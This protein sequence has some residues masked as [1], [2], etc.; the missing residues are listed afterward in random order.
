MLPNRPHIAWHALVVRI[1]LDLSHP[2]RGTMWHRTTAIAALMLLAT[3][4]GGNKAK[5]ENGAY[6]IELENRARQIET[7]G[8]NQA[9][10][11]AAVSTNAAG[12]APEAPLSNMSD[13]IKSGNVSGGNMSSGH[14]PYQSSNSMS[15]D[16]G[17]HNS[18]ANGD[19]EPFCNI[20]QD[21]IPAA[22]CDY[23]QEVWNRL[24]S[25]Q[26]AFDVPQVMRRGVTAQVSFAL[27]RAEQGS[28]AS[29]AAASLLDS[30]PER[31]ATIRVGRRMAVNLSGEGFRIEPQGLQER[32]LGPGGQARWDWRV[33]PE[34][35]GHKTLTISA[36]V[37]VQPPNGPRTENLIRTLSQEVDVDVSA[38]D[39]A[40]DIAEASKSWLGIANEW[41][42]ALA[43]L[44]GGGVLALILALRRVR[45]KKEAGNSTPEGPAH[46][47]EGDD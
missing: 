38:S 29:A 11:N 12:P 36:Y 24:G 41:L 9:D 7:T 40:K 14:T 6:E 18:M 13:Y 2:G 21:R 32:D 4:G 10:A 31:S 19:A 15:G 28:D 25:G 27:V 16:V 47:P 44:I 22:E 35:R 46:P 23:Y 26:A 43:A 3:C 37:V 30:A 8:E 42:L 45:R 20:I 5:T 39:R 34:V 33:T 1:I 17:S